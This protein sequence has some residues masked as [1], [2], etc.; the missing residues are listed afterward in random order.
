MHL[1][2]RA[3]RTAALEPP[4]F[5]PC[6][7][8]YAQGPLFAPCRARTAPRGELFDPGGRLD[9]LFLYVGAEAIAAARHSVDE[10]LA[11]RPF[12]QCL[13]QHEDGLGQVRLL[14]EPVGRSQPHQFGLVDDAIAA[15]NEGEQDVERFGVSGTCSPARIRRRSG[16]ASR[17]G[18]KA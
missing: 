17:Y 16:T 14:N 11:V 3:A 18:P 1:R 6:V 13:A 9:N 8:G 4:L 7:R 10:R 5:Y 12:A 2:G 15:L